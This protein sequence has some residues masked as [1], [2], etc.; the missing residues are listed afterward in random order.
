MIAAIQV[1]LGGWGRSWA[2]D[3]VPKV[4]G[5]RAVG[6]VDAAPAALR[7]AQRELG[8]DKALCFT[9][10]RAAA[11]AVEAE[12]V[13]APVRTAAHVQVVGEALDLGFHVLVEKPFAPT[14]AEAKSL[15]DQ[16]ERAGRVLAVSQNYRHYEAPRAVAGLVKA[17][18]LGRPGLVSVDFRRNPPSGTFPYF[19]L[20]DPLLGDMAIHHFD[21]MRMVLGT[22]PV[23]VACESFNPPKSRYEGDAV[24][25]ALIEFEGGTVVSYRGSWVSAGARTPWAGEW[26]MDFP[27]AEVRWTSRNTDRKRLTPDRLVITRP[28]KPPERPKLPRVGLRDRQGALAMIRT[29]IETGREPAWFSSG[30]D[31]LRSLAISEAAIASAARGGNWIQIAD[32]VG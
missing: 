26:A 30:R 10:L 28:G 21:L 22:E 19:D 8:I 1:G 11:A 4:P 3:V 23:R 31:N 17:G 24:G 5:I 18:R 20:P 27:G 13:I 32:I 15:V 25:A 9:S 6:Y 16:A 2:R 14:V 12:L 7:K 29:A